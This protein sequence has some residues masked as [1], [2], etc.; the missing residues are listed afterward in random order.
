MKLLHL[1]LVLFAPLIA[2]PTAQI[3]LT[4]TWKA[5]FN[6]PI[7][8]RPKPFGDVVFRL[9]MADGH[10]TGT[11]IM[12]S[13]P[14]EAPLTDIKLDGEQFSATAI[15]TKGWSSGSAAMAD[16]PRINHCC[17]KMIFAGTIEGSQINLTMV[18]TSTEAAPEEA[19]TEN[20][21]PLLAT[22]ISDDPNA[23]VPE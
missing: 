15:G 22:K 21:I 10:V 2:T 19:L 16:Q 8:E 11:A 17:P 18:W 5:T 23:T 12:G 9:R 14:G 13:W 4:G 20:K 6:G 1:V 7:G 3:N